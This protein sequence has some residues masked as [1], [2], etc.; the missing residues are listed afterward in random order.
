MLQSADVFLLEIPFK[1]GYDH[2]QAARRKTSSVILRLKDQNGLMAFGETT[3]R[4]YVT[5]E[6]VA[7]V[8]KVVSE[9]LPLFKTYDGTWECIKEMGVRWGD[10]NTAAWCMVEMA[11]LNHCNAHLH[12]T[13]WEQMGIVKQKSAP[14]SATITGGNRD[15]FLL[16]AQMFCMNG[17]KQVKLKLVEDN[18]EN[19]WRINYL[20]GL[21]NED[22]DIRVDGNEIWNFDKNKE[23]IQ[24]LCRAGIHYFEQPFHKEDVVSAQKFY[25]AFGADVKL[26]LDDSITTEASLK[27]WMALNCI[28]GINIKIAKN[29]GLFRA[30]K[31]AQMCIGHGWSVQLGSH[32]GETS[33]LAYWGEVFSH[34]FG[35]KIVYKEGAFS[36]HLL[37]EDPFAPRIKFSKEGILKE[38][39]DS[40]GTEVDFHNYPYASALKG[41]DI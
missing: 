25:T 38:V 39:P 29:G 14:Y 1:F 32:V 13:I 15:E 33:L 7:S 9:N 16:M 2:A 35:D 31:L 27:K 19:I 30:I 11:L 6:D 28:H 4:P 18:A 26:I 23:D 10:Q 21:Y 22:V 24:A 40:V 34:C 8:Q 5:G 12:T 3:P 41:F 20:R 37:I 36:D 17:M